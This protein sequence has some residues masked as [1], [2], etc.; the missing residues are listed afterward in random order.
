[1]GPRTGFHAILAVAAPLLVTACGGGSAGDFVNL[2][3]PLD[4]I[5]TIQI[6]SPSAVYFS[7]DQAGTTFETRQSASGGNNRVTVFSNYSGFRVE[8]ET[9]G[10]LIASSA[11][12]RTFLAA[13]LVADDGTRRT[14][15]DANAAFDFEWIVR[16]PGRDAN[17]LPEHVSFGR[18]SRVER[19]TGSRD[20]GYLAFGLL[21]PTIDVPG[22]GTATYTG[23]AEGLLDV[24]GVETDLTGTSTVDVDFGLG[25]AALTLDFS[26]SPWAR[27][28]TGA[29]TN[30]AARNNAFSGTLASGTYTG[31]FNANFYGRA[32][33]AQTGPEEVGGVW[34]VTDGNAF[35]QGAFIAEQ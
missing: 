24:A 18:W 6:Y 23:V 17:A 25:T 13:N 33:P 1:M 16:L 27:T 3:T 28:L 19:S 10:T 4:Q 12:D 31:T 11:M 5:G 35:A 34:S 22:A 14:Y 30:V 21:A 26:A 29:S 15:T 7:R 2:T 9:P 20:R 8:A 32:D